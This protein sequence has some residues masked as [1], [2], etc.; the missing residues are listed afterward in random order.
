MKMIKMNDVVYFDILGN[1]REK[2]YFCVE[3]KIITSAWDTIR[4]EGEGEFED[5]MSFIIK[6]KILEE[7]A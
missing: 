6:N 5:D 4:I 2:I 7:K 3:R 1:I